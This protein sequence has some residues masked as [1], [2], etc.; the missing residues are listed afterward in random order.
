VEW[1]PS[2]Q[3]VCTSGEHFPTSLMVPFFNKIM[4]TLSYALVPK[5]LKYFYETIHLASQ[6]VLVLDAIGIS[7]L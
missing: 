5:Q 4:L 7:V 3:L 6:M 1:N 2:R